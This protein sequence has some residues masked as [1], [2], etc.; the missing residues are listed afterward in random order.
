ML[1]LGCEYLHLVATLQFVAQ[2]HQFVVHLCSDTVASEEGVDGEGKVESRTSGGHGLNLA[3]RCE[4]E[5]LRCEEV[6]LDGVEEVHCVGLRVVEYFLD[7][8]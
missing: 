6:E 2:R 4:D 8:V 5:Y 1:R 7:S 3:L